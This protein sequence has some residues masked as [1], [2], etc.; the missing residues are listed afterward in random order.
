VHE[1]VKLRSG[2]PALGLLLL[3]SEEVA[4][5]VERRLHATTTY[6]LVMPLFQLTQKRQA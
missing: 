1:P 6:Q 4:E 2:A 5:V 3:V